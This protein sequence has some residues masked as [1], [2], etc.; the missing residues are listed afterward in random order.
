[1]LTTTQTTSIQP[2]SVCDGYDFC[3]ARWE[4]DGGGARS[5]LPPFKDFK[6]DHG[7]HRSPFNQPDQQPTA[8]P[9]QQSWTGEWP[10]GSLLMSYQSRH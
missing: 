7:N 4:D 8:R 10:D 2:C 9:D 3:L 1:M 5:P 6:H